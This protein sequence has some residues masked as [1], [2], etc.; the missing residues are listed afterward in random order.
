MENWLYTLNQ[1]TLLIFLF[2]LLLASLLIGSAAGRKI[3]KEG[4]QDSQ[5]TTIQ[6][7]ILGLL[8]LLL[9]FTFS[10][11]ANRYEA[12]RELVLMESNAIGTAYLRAQMLP[13]PYQTQTGD[14]LRNY[15]DA[16][17]EFYNAGVAPVRLKDA[18]DKSIRIQGQLWQ[19][20]VD[21]SAADPRSEPTSLFVQSLND[22]IDLH[23]ARLA[24]MNNR[25]PDVILYLIFITSMLTVAFIGYSMRAIHYHRFIPALITIFLIVIIVGVIIDLDRPRRGLIQI[26]QESMIQLQQTIK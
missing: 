20:A 5:V 4:D 7:A 17:L 23:A 22:V 19:Q 6:A 26:S 14:L 15:V 8:G 16:R 21:V 10:M 1:G 12:R 9:A 2:L 24:A 25:V 11:S 3:K 18:L 13:E